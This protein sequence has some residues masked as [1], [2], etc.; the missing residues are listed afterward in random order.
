MVAVLEVIALDAGGIDVAV[1]AGE[2]HPLLIAGGG[3]RESHL[4]P[5]L[6]AGIRAFHA[7]TAVRGKEKID[8]EKVRRWVTLIEDGGDRAEPVDRGGDGV[9]RLHRDRGGQ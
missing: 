6:A 9:A 3:L 7:S 1:L 8:A 2:R 5:L 4:E